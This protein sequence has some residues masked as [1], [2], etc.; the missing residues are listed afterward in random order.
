MT[1]LNDTP[2][3]SMSNTKKE[4]LDA[5]QAIKK[6]L[7][8]REKQVL[9]AEKSRKQME[10]KIAETTADAQ[11][12]QDPLQR[13]Y[14]LKGDI[15]RDLTTLAEKFE[16]EID[17]Y[18][19]IKAALKEKQE[20]LHT[21]Y[22]IE[23]AAS[24]LAALIEAQQA[25]KDAF[26]REMES[27][28]NDFKEEIQEARAKWDKGKDEREQAAKEQAEAIKKQRQREKEEYEYT[29]AREKEQRKNALEDELHAVENEINQNRKDFEQDLN[30]RSTALEAREKSFAE[31]EAEMARL[32]KEVETFPQKLN[33]N[34]HEAVAATT[35][36]LTSDFEKT[37]ALLEAKYDGEKNVFTSKIE[38]L[39]KLVSSQEAQMA[40]LTKRH[41][42][43][44][45]KVQ[46]IANR[47][48]AAAKREFISVPMTSRTAFDQDERNK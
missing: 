45:E 28:Q 4:M 16:Q 23:T 19:K 8:E 7:Q 48:V 29:F 46:D 18:R 25:K 42:Q 20:E 3:V 27:R 9:D 11:A 1:E 13:L 6:Q 5:Y 24:D 33:T 40:Q 36:R 44:Y 37:K 26:E 39:E 14:A 43:A 41:E 38:F 31:K 22:E 32:Q 35:E 47:A 12:S 21:L 34:V 30:Q 10:K 2:A 15:S 17:T